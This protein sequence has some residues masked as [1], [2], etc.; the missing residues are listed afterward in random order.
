MDRGEILSQY[1]VVSNAAEIIEAYRPLVTEIK[2]D[3]ISIQ[4][5]S[6][7]PDRAIAMIGSEVL[8][9]LRSLTR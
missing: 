6:I 1:T 7:H 2:A 5:A 3:V 9:E 4:V 8:P